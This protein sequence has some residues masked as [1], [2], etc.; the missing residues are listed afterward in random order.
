M[1]LT[2]FKIIL[3]LTMICCTGKSFAQ[4]FYVKLN[5]GYNL[6]SAYARGSNQ[7]QNGTVTS[8]ESAPISL[9]KGASFGALVGYMF[10]D[11]WGAEFGVNYLMGSTFTITQKQDMSSYT[12]N[13]SSKMLSFVPTI[14]F[15]PGFEKINPY[16][17]LGLIIGTGSFESKSVLNSSFNNQNETTLSNGGLAYGLV[18]TF[19]TTYTINDHVSLFGEISLINLSNSPTKSEITESKINGV[20]NLP[21][22]STRDKITE[23][24]DSYTDDNSNNPNN[25]TKKIAISVPFSSVGLNLGIKYNF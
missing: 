16:A 8:Y 19:G 12:V 7:T 25:P 20:D 24:S 10:N 6:G 5:G 4:N 1:K 21:N 14:V 3:L 17:K 15:T 18:G 9:G 23:F 11:Y 13:I 22:M 2:N